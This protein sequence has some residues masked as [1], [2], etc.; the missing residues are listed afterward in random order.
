MQ[1]Q[2]KRFWKTKNEDVY[3]LGSRIEPDNPFRIPPETEKP[4]DPLELDKDDDYAKA[5]AY[6]SNDDAMS[7]PGK[8]D[9]VLHEDGF[10]IKEI[11]HI[12]RH[13]QVRS[14]S[15]KSPRLLTLRLPRLV[16]SSLSP[17]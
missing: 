14:T 15:L 5:L 13:A 12:G 17:P 7:K 4:Y 3:D 9:F 6:I 10:P 1:L 11:I 16:V 2:E 8:S